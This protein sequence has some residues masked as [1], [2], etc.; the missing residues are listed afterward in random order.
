M[1]YRL[2]FLSQFLQLSVLISLKKEQDKVSNKGTI[3]TVVNTCLKAIEVI[4]RTGQFAEPVPHLF[5]K[6][7]MVG[8]PADIQVR[9]VEFKS[10]TET[11]SSLGKYFKDILDNLS[12]EDLTD[13]V[14]ILEK[15]DELNKRDNP[16]LV[17][18][19]LVNSA[20]NHTQKDY[21]NKLQFKEL[22][23]R[24]IKAYKYDL[25]KRIQKVSKMADAEAETGDINSFLDFGASLQSLLT[26]MSTNNSN[27]LNYINKNSD[28]IYLIHIGVGKG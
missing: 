10:C 6:N 5:D 21:F 22:L 8:I 4:K 3:E 17:A 20:F 25:E 2:S 16:F 19:H 14:S 15:W 12:V 24:E 23:F 27:L 7:Y 11:Y 13:T 18:S 1:Y 9:G 28:M 26:V